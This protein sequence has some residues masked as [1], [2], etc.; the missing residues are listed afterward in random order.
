MDNNLDLTNLVEDEEKA[1]KGQKVADK[2]IKFSQYGLLV[3]VI[4]SA[5][6][7]INAYNNGHLDSI[8]AMRTYIASFGG[9][10]F[11]ILTALQ[12]MQVAQR[13]SRSQPKRRLISP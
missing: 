13:P 9:W 1:Q 6:F 2:L 10:G 3:L 7:C 12:T 4:V 8:E 11:L 5:V